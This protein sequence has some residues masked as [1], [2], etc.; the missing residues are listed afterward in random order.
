MRK[1]GK[2]TKISKSYSIDKN[3][4]KKFEEYSTENCT[5]SSMLVE[6]LIKNHLEK[7]GEKE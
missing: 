2:R 5:N 3:L 4:A 6:K 1:R 7:N